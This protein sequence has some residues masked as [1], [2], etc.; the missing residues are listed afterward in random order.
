MIT[1]EWLRKGIYVIVI[2]G[3]CGCILYTASMGATMMIYTM[4]SGGDCCCFQGIFND[5]QDGFDCGITATHF[6]NR[7]FQGNPLK[8]EETGNGP[9]H[10]DWW[11]TDGKQLK[12]FGKVISLVN[13]NS[14]K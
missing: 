9:L 12:Q 2:S 4:L 8:W 5:N 14:R 11:S 6:A 13:R 10:G 1:N 3:Q 7:T